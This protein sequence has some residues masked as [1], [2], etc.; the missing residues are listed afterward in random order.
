M[1]NDEMEGYGTKLVL[2]LTSPALDTIGG[3]Q[4]TLRSILRVLFTKLTHNAEVV[5]VS[6]LHVCQTD[7][8]SCA[9]N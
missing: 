5:L 1:V 7:V 6:L 9:K 8:L 2:S 4:M 3:I